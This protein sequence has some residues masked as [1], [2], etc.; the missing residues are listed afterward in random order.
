MLYIVDRIEEGMIVLEN[1]DEQTF[2]V[3]K[4]LLPDAKEGD[5]VEITINNEETEKRRNNIRRLMEDLLQD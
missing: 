5:C 1:D 3:P 4:A 2:S